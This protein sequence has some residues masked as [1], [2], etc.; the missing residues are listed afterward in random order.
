MLRVSGPPLILLGIT[1]PAT[2]ISFQGFEI[3]GLSSS[4]LVTRLPEKK[5]LQKAI[6]GEIL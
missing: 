1:V 3:M 6:F 4:F 2:D 5:Y